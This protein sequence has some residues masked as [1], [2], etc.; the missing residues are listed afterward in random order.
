MVEMANL[1]RVE[2]CTLDGRVVAQQSANGRNANIN[3]SS[4]ASGM[5]IIKAIDANNM[6]TTSKFQKQQ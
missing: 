1:S 5:Y 2:V 4:L 6:Y 3:I